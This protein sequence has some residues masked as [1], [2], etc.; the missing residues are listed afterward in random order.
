MRLVGPAAVGGQVEQAVARMRADVARHDPLALTD[1][2]LVERMVATPV[3]ELMVSIRRDPQFGL[4]MTLA[5]GGTL[6]E[7]LADATTLL[8]PAT[9]GD[10]RR[11]LGKLRADRLID[12]YRGKPAGDRDGLLDVLERLADY[13]ADSANRVAEIEI[14]P[15]FVFERGALVVDV[16]LQKVSA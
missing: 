11:A 12:G 9:R 15:V 8:L 7:L 5:S 6:V 10:F 14:N 1:R 16:L 13:A 2:F 4:A 3:V